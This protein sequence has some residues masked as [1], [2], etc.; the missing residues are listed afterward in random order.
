LKK[1]ERGKPTGFYIIIRYPGVITDRAQ[2][3]NGGIGAA[4]AE[5]TIK[6]FRCRKINSSDKEFP[7]E[8]L[9]KNSLTIYRQSI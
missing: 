8:R 9:F 3:Y 7:R 5:A 6:Y 4:V 1:R 2:K